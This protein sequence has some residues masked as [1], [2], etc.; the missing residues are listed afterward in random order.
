MVWP[1]LPYACCMG[2][3]CLCCKI[4]VGSAQAWQVMGLT[5]TEGLVKAAMFQCWG[6]VVVSNTGVLEKAQT[7]LEGT[8]YSLGL[9][10]ICELPGSCVGVSQL[11]HNQEEA[12]GQSYSPTLPRDSCTQQ[13]SQGTF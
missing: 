13:W 11:W 7:I 4:H 3:L 9:S 5:V 1:I 2:A 12:A 6:V 8:S 10:L